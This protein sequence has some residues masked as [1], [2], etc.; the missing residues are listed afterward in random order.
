MKPEAILSSINVRPRQVYLGRGLHTLG[1]I[2]W[3]LQQTGRADEVIVTTFSTSIDFLSGFY[4]LRQR[5]LIDKAIMVADVKAA[6]KTWRLD[7]LLNSAFDHV[8]LS[9]N[10]SKIV[11]ISAGDKRISVISSQN[12]TYGGRTE[13]TLIDTDSEIYNT[14]HTAIDNLLTQSFVRK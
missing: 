2:S 13:C 6:K 11:L 7:N 12:N 8:Y 4:N 5:G 1:L 3:I 14:L 10:H 9:E